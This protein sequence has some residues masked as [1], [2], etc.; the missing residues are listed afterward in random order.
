EQVGDRCHEGWGAGG[1]VPAAVGGVARLVDEQ[2]VGGR[3]LLFV[4][5]AAGVGDGGCADVDGVDFDTGL[6]GV[7]AGGCPATGAGGDGD[8]QV[9]PPGQ[10]GGMAGPGPA[11]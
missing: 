11:P 3:V 6:V 7:E 9:G 10:A 2:P 8:G 4:R 5:G 1:C